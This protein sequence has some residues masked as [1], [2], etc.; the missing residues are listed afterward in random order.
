MGTHK[1]TKTKTKNQATEI[2]KTKT[3]PSEEMLIDKIKKEIKHEN[4]LIT[5]DRS[6]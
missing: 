4:V 6:I 3:K 2:T 5:P 1:I